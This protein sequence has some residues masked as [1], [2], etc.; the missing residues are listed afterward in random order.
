[1][2]PLIPVPDL[3][4][5][6]SLPGGGL[7][8]AS[9]VCGVLA[10]L[11]GV[12]LIGGLFGLVGLILGLIAFATRRP[13]RAFAGWGIG[14]SVVG[15]V[16]ACGMVAGWYW[17]WTRGMGDMVS[18]I[19]TTRAV[20]FQP[21]E[22]IGQPMPELTLTALD[23]RTIRTADWKG[24]RAVV[25]VW[26]SWHPGCAAAVPDFVRLARE[27]ADRGVQIVAVTFEDAADVAAFVRERDLNYPIVATNDLPAPLGQVASVP[28]TFFIDETGII[29][30]IRVGYEGYGAL[31][32]AALGAATRNEEGGP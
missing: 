13:R 31:K 1:M 30:D 11:L 28:T 5:P 3:P 4:Q 8:I 9:F 6:A 27:T 29:R 32:Q 14:L 15:I 26:A 10:V 20:P 25:D 12:V 7:A 24:H 16:L 22:W 2:D 17:Y 23:G 19:Q 21:A 18:E